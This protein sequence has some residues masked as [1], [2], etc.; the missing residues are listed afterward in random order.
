MSTTD[1]VGSHN[2]SDEDESKD[3]LDLKTNGDAEESE[4]DS[5]SES[6]ADTDQDRLSPNATNNGHHRTHK[7]GHR[8]RAGKRKRRTFKIKNALITDK[9]LVHQSDTETRKL[10]DDI[11]DDDDYAYLDEAKENTQIGQSLNDFYLR[12]IETE[13]N[14]NECGQTDVKVSLVGTQINLT[15][16]VRETS[17]SF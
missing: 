6:E 5:R 14:F 17:G 16:I 3:E 4:T 9:L 8:R 11:G 2:W 1:E 13:Q 15:F 12:T 7:K 10:L